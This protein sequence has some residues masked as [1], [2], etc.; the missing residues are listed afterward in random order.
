MDP[1]KDQLNGVTPPS[2]VEPE[3][4][5]APEPVITDDKGERTIDNVRGELVRKLEDSEKR[6]D[7]KLDA[8]LSRM[9]NI[10]TDIA[11]RTQEPADKPASTTGGNPLDSYSVDQLQAAMVNENID[12]ATKQSIQAYIPVRVAREEAR[13]I[14]DENRLVDAAAR[15]KQEAN[16]A[17]VDRY[18][19]LVD[20]ATALH[21]EVNRILLARGSQTQNP[22]AVLDAANEA[23]ARLG[24]GIKSQ[25]RQPRVPGKPGG[26]GNQAPV[27]DQSGEEYEGMTDAEIDAIAPKLAHLLG[28]NKDGTQKTFDKTFIKERSKLYKDRY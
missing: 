13:R 24:V 12:D 1:L 10:Q 15:T 2:P 19:D 9:D 14:G 23:A 7:A 22:T 20:P 28:R 3:I 11:G 8:I 25:S 5:P 17:A 21:K 18:P 16:Q 4:E 6:S 27:T 26:L